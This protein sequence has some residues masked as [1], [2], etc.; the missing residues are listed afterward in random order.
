MKRALISVFHKEGIVEFASELKKL[1]W[2]IISTGGTYKILKESGI[3][4]IEVNNVTNFPEILDGRVKTLNPYIHGG[5]LYIR[6]N[7]N[8]IKTIEDMKIDPIDMVVNNLYPFEETINKLNV[9]HEEIIENIDIGGP[10]MI[11]AAAKNYKDVTVIIDP[12]DYEQVLNELKFEGKTTFRTRQYLARK[13]FN[14]TAYYDTLIS[15]YFNEIEEV[16]FPE[17]LTLA[18]KSKE[19]LRY[20]ENPHQKAAF[21][22]EV[23]K[24]EGTLAGAIQLHGKE[25]SFNNINDANGCIEALKEFDEPTVVAVKHANPCGI[26][27]GKDILEAYKKAYECDK[28][29]IFGGIIAANREI[30][31]K[32][33]EK[34]NQIFIEIVMAP[35]FTEK[36]LEILT[37]KKNIRIM[38]IDSII[39]RKYKELDIKKVLG[40]LLVQDKDRILLNEEIKIVTKNQPTEKQM[41][42]L[43]FAWKAAK[44]VKSNGVVIAKDKATIGIGLG[45][46]NRVWA[47]QNAIE[48]AGEKVKGAVLASDGFFPFKDS[49]ELLS[50]AGVA[51]IIQPGG[52]LKDSEVIE[53]ADKNSISMIITGIRHFKH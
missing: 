39:D 14:Y 43:L 20:G 24:K 52:S 22:K 32:V 30:D 18:Y 2:E 1:G 25:L 45:E 13:V 40:G 51:A 44:S 49:I 26:G 15:N 17:K 48:R 38:Q 8:H 33:A 46:V 12:S 53:E 21:Y 42:D 28:V 9:T 31:E 27:S 41:E 29:S 4:V 3:E 7:E 34:I 5:L 47:V 11:R 37:Q 16:I 6:D 36:A 23:G 50:S 10:S 19:E 35:S